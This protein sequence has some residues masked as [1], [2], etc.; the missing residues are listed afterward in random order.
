M[1]CSLLLFSVSSDLRMLVNLVHSCVQN[2]GHEKHMLVHCML[3]VFFVL[4]LK[5]L[6]LYE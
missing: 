1:A 3:I 2:K 5:K 6:K 4:Q